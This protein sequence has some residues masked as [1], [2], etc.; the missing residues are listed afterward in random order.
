MIEAQCRLIYGMEAEF[1]RKL[2]QLE[3]MFSLEGRSIG[4]PILIED[5]AVED[6]VTLIE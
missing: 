2:T 3:R 6:M 4:N 5:D 1:N